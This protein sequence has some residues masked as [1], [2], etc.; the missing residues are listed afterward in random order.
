MAACLCIDT[1]KNLLIQICLKVKHVMHVDTF[2]EKSLER[3]IALTNS[4]VNN[5][6]IIY[7]I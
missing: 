4:D 7:R 2:D 5:I 1:V 6:Y 3:I